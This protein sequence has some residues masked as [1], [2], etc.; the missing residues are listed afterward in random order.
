MHP[1]VVAW[2]GYATGRLA[3]GVRGS[4][5][6]GYLVAHNLLLVSARGPGGGPRRGEGPWSTPLSRLQHLGAMGPPTPDWHNGTTLYSAE[7]CSITVTLM[8]GKIEGRRNVDDRR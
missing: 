2:H 3:P 4:P 5:R 8:Q 7:I 1:Y 6:L